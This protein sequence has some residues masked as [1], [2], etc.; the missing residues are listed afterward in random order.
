MPEYEMDYPQL[1]KLYSGCFIAH[2]DNQVLADAPTYEEL[3]QQLRRLDVDRENLV[4]EYIEP[5]DAIHV[6]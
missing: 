4:I 2:Q 6:Y 1:Q 3:C 5:A